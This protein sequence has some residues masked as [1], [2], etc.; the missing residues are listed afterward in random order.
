MVSHCP[1]NFNLLTGAQ[2]IDPGHWWNSSTEADIMPSS[3]GRCTYHIWALLTTTTKISPKIPL[4]VKGNAIISFAFGVDSQYGRR[5]YRK[6]ANLRHVKL[7]YLKTLFFVVWI[8]TSANFICLWFLWPDTLKVN[9]GLIKN[10]KPKTQKSL[11]LNQVISI[12]SKSQGATK[13][14]KIGCNKLV[15]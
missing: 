1:P 8:R 7:D 6:L 4:T 5:H 9:V 14:P 12:L 10:P 13:N 2:V 11:S 15:L 3:F